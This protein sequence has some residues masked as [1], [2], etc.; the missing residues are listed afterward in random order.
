MFL[1]SKNN[2]ASSADLVKSSLKNSTEIGPQSTL[3]VF[4]SRTEAY[5]SCD[6]LASLSMYV[7]SVS[8][9]C[10]DRVVVGQGSTNVIVKVAM[11][12]LFPTVPV[13]SKVYEPG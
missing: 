3:V 6:S 4:A 5:H 13:I 9:D 2:S 8:P 7:L 1:L 11:S 12:C 10:K